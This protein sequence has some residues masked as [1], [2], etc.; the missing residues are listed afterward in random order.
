MVLENYFYVKRHLATSVAAT[1]VSVGL[2]LFPT[3]I[4]YLEDIY[5]WKGVAMLLIALCLNILMC[6][7]LMRQVVHYDGRRRRDLL[8]IFEPSLFK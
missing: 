8:K 6:G 7:C 4:Y 2:M 3:A 1:G 5:A